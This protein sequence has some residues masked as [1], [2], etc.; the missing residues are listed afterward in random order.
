MGVGTDLSSVRSVGLCLSV[1][2]EG[3][4]ISMPFGVVNGVGRG[5]GVL[6]GVEIVDGIEGA[7]LGVNV[8]HPVVTNTDFGLVILCR[9]GWRRGSSQITLGF[10]VTLTAL[11]DSARYCDERVCLF[12]CLS[13]CT[14]AY[15][16]NHA[17]EFHQIFHAY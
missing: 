4:W 8:G 6:D 5:M 10:L 9:E 7:V 11:Y 15:L 2:P 12:V 3:D 1:C 17:F 14:I 13:V 16:R